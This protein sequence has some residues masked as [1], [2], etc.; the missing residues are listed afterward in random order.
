MARR[1]YY[2]RARGVY[3]R[4]RNNYRRYRSSAR[5]TYRRGQSYARR[6]NTAIGLYNPG[7]EYLA[8]AVVGLT[9]L[10]NKIPAPLKIIGASLPL[11]GGIGGKVS[12]FFRGV[13][14]GDAVSYY[15]K[16][17]IPIPGTDGKG[18]SNIKWG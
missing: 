3:G 10:D 4:Y 9:S 6:A 7:T 15:T 5:R 14:L 1:N 12:R 13:L 17:Q 18:S 2:N 11:R 16:L 8:G